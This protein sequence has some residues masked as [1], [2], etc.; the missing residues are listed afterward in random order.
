MRGLTRS[1]KSCRT[2]SIAVDFAGTL[3]LKIF[4]ICTDTEHRTRS[5]C[6]WPQVSSSTSAPCLQMCTVSVNPMY[7]SAMAIYQRKA[8]SICGC[9]NLFEI[10]SSSSLAFLFAKLSQYLFLP[11]FSK[12][13]TSAIEL[14]LSVYR[15]LAPALSSDNSTSIARSKDSPELIRT[16]NR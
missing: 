2:G 7:K 9:I 6:S 4:Q 12:I 14:T 5:I 8:V 16:N 1:P 10:V 3:G 11:Y 13:S 15:S